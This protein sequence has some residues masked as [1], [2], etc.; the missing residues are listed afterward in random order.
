LVVTIVLLSLRRIVS[1][2]FVGRFARRD[3]VAD[4]GC[5][6]DGTDGNDAVCSAGTAAGG[7]IVSESDDGFTS[8]LTLSL[9]S[10]RRL[11]FLTEWMVDTF[12]RWDTF[13]PLFELLMSFLQMSALGTASTMSALGTA[14]TDM[15]LSLSMLLL[16]LES[17]GLHAL[18]FSHNRCDFTNL[19]LLPLA[20]LSKD[21]SGGVAGFDVNPCSAV[22]K[23]LPQFFS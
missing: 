6:V 8:A 5:T 9:F 11:D 1:A 14:S 20:S 7:A 21:L 15:L 4:V 23:V 12:R 19:A 3:C 22:A 18:Y 13:L 2:V 17:V 16:L 10:E